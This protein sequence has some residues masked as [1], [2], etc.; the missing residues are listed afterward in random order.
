MPWWGWTIIWALLS[1]ALLG[2]LALFA[3]SLFRKLT[4]IAI[5]L[6]HLASQTAR[7]DQTNRVLDDQ[8]RELAILTGYLEV[9]RRRERVRSAALLRKQARR[10]ASIQR[11]KELIRVDATQKDW[12]PAHDQASRHNPR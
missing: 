10:R 3:V 1:L 6:E 8:R 11:A 7:L 9:R 4:A 12:F 2:M 5:E